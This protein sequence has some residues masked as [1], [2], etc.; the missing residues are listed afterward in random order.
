[1]KQSNLLI[2]G[3]IFLSIFLVIICGIAIMAIF[4]RSGLGLIGASTP[5]GDMAAIDTAAAETW[6]VMQT[7]AALSATPTYTPPPPSPTATITPVPTVTRTPTP[8]RTPVPVLTQP[9]YTTPTTAVSFVPTITGTIKPTSTK[10]AST[11]GATKTKP[12][13]TSAPCLQAKFIKDITVPDLSKLPSQSVFKKVWRIQNT[14]SCTW[15]EDESYIVHENGSSLGG[16]STRLPTT[17]KPG[18]NVDVQVSLTSPTL[19]G[20]YTG[21]WLLKIDGKKL[22]H[23]S[24]GKQTFDVAIESTYT[25]SGIVFDYASEFCTALWKNSKNTLTCPGKLTSEQGFA[26]RANGVKMEDGLIYDNVLL[27]Q[28]EFN[29]D[30]IIQGAYPSILIQVGDR[31]RANTGCVSTYEKCNVRVEVFIRVNEGNKFLLD[32]WVEI[33]DGLYYSLDEDLSAFAGSWVSLT[34]VVD[35]KG[36]ANQDTIGWILPQLYRP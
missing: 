15:A 31:F 4:F 11:P 25:A 22:G 32:E 2:F 10:S 12:P 16:V 7:D 24:N 33:Y 6:V 5:L 20:L 35:A 13:A 19:P 26:L 1:M 29:N 8:T 14:G 27:T 34:F 9:Q 30:G 36:S 17:V 21:G 23:G 3:L 28:P 18:Q